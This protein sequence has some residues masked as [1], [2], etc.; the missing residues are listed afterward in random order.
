MEVRWQLIRS[1]ETSLASQ[2][3]N[4]ELRKLVARARSDR[5][6]LKAANAEK[7]KKFGFDF[8]KQMQQLRDELIRMKKAHGDGLAEHENYMTKVNGRL[9]AM[10]HTVSDEAAARLALHDE[11]E[12]LKFDLERVEKELADVHAIK[13]TDAQRNTKTI[14]DLR[15][16]LGEADTQNKTYMEKIESL[17]TQVKNEVLTRESLSEEV[18]RLRLWVAKM[19]EKGLIAAAEAEEQ[20]QR[21]E[22]EHA[23]A[24]QALTQEGNTL[25]GTVAF[26]QDE[27]YRVQTA[28]HVPPTNSHF[29]KFV[30]LKSENR[31]LQSKLEKTLRSQA[32]APLPG[33]TQDPASSGSVASTSTAK[34]QV[35]RAPAKG[36]KGNML[37]PGPG[38]Q[39][40]S[41]RVVPPRAH[42]PG[43]E[44]RS[45]SGGQGSR[46]KVVLE[47]PGQKTII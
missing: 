9:L 4:L 8:L 47:V 21:M 23:L 20:K 7:I 42:P 43:G 16:Q 44:I 24:V 27:L 12:R 1:F 40:T 15:A 45:S 25:R 26:L 2:N 29:G 33:H 5:D 6:A 19:E 10:S 36:M 13:G 35:K 17:E 41:P 3:E 37:Q 34:G 14:E 46:P 22:S 30:E 11:N 18:K 38:P 31:H 28:L 32:A 39:Q